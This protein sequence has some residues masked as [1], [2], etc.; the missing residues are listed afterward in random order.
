MRKREEYR[1]LSHVHHCVVH[2]FCGGKSSAST[3]SM[4]QPIDEHEFREKLA[5]KVVR[6]CPVGTREDSL[7]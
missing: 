1:D 7:E 2:S 3:S 6:L 4:K 5:V